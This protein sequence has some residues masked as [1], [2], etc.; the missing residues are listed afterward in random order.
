MNKA[1]V[2]VIQCQD[3]DIQNVYN[4]IKR[5][6]DLLGGISS[7][8]SP[9][10]KILLKPNLLSASLPQKAITT[11]PAVFEAVAR[12][13]RE[14]GCSHIEY[15]D[16]PGNPISSP[17]QAARAAG[18]A[19]AADKY[20]IIPGDFSSFKT[21]YENDHALPLCNAVLQCDA[22]I[23]ICKMKTHALERITGAVKNLY[24]CVHGPNKAI[25]HAKYPDPYA[26]AHY[27]CDIHTYTKPRLHIMDGIIA[28]EGNG[29]TSG[30][31]VKMGVLLLSKDPVA[32]DTVFCRLI[33]L[34]PQLVP[35]N[36]AGSQRGIGTYDIDKIVILTADG[37]ISSDDLFSRF[38][39]AEFDVFRGKMKKSMIF[40]LLPLLPFLQDR[41]HVNKKVCTGCGLC[42][43]AC[44]VPEK[45]VH[46]GNG[47]KAVY[48]HRKCI[49][50][51]CCQEM[52]PSKAITVRRGL[53]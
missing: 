27:L 48:D 39:S 14:N 28:M 34:E 42:E 40:K 52:C 8:V 30:T 23:N 35:T 22:L 11:H 15:G 50:C 24:G 7:F 4:A 37:I 26:F 17:Y 20:S 16:S 44:P 5:G 36:I 51:F 10:E 47:H 19:E 49:R 45:A 9:E 6:I 1:A 25:G 29:P 2:C 21:V 41:P 46:S 31:P 18:I 12:I 32:L 43:K 53:L 33:D 3:Y 38:G 13:L